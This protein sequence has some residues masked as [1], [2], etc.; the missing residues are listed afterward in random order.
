ME[1]LDCRAVIALCHA[2][3]P[4]Q[5]IVAI[6]IQPFVLVIRQATKRTIGSIAIRQRRILALI[7]VYLTH[8]GKRIIGIFHA[9]P[10]AVAHALQQAAIGRIAVAGKGDVPHTDPRSLAET[11]IAHTISLG[12]GRAARQL[13]RARHTRHPPVGVG[14][15]QRRFRAVAVQNGRLGNAG[16]IRVIGRAAD[17]A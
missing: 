1:D 11:V 14:I 13:R 10:I 8:S 9:V 7:I 6:D 16:I 2:Q 5:P 12:E 17:S 3:Q 15:T 4:V